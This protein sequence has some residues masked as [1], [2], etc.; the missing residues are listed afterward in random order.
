M[1]ASVAE[2]RGAGAVVRRRLLL[3]AGY[4][5][6]ALLFVGSREPLRREGLWR[7]DGISVAIARAPTSRE[8]F[9]RLSFLDSQPPLFPASLAVWGRTFGW[10]ESSIKT[11]AFLWGCAAVASLTVLA[12]SLF[13]PIAGLIA[14]MLAATHPL[15]RTLPSDL[16]PYST[17]IVFVSLALAALFATRVWTPLRRFALLAPL[18][19][20]L[21][22]SQYTGTLVGVLVGAVALVGS[23][24]PKSRP[25]WL[26][27]L[28]AAVVA[29]LLFLPWLPMFLAHRRIGL[30]WDPTL[31]LAERASRLS[32]R[33]GAVVPW[34]RSEWETASAIGCLVLFCV[35]IAGWPRI[36]ARRFPWPPLLVAACAAT[37]FVAMS[38]FADPP[39]YLVVPAALASVL[40]AGAIARLSVVLD[41]GGLRAFATL[42]GALIIGGAL[43]SGA[44][45]TDL[46]PAADGPLAKSGSRA[47]C[48]QLAPGSRD[49]VLP[50]PDFAATSLWYYCGEGSPLHGFPHWDDPQLPRWDRYRAMWEEPVPSLVRRLDEL[51]DRGAIDR[52]W[53]VQL[54][55]AGA[56]RA[57]PGVGPRLAE[58]AR[59]LPRHFAA[60]RPRRF[61]G[62][63]EGLI[64]TELRRSASPGPTSIIPDR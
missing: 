29:G 16:R 47:F 19:V 10:A 15:L 42:G 35:A 48:S 17:S 12:A 20:L 62:R 8:F 44:S 50:I 5:L 39:R 46:S 18:F 56:L 2:R 57:I 13:G 7:D 26:P 41:H 4:T 61:G 28:G 38:F 53:L 21:V 31:T 9:R 32:G 1:T 14:L 43:L 23:L 25:F 33:L 24:H 59:V 45:A 60:G 63:L 55:D 64:A 34:I 40:A 51:F 52:V 36:R 54:E 6:L 11:L 3:A 37:V 30:P 49:L 22:Y 27:V 58:A